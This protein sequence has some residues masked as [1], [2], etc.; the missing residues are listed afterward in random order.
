MPQGWFGCVKPRRIRRPGK[1]SVSPRC[2][3]SRR[4][5][6]LFQNACGSG[7]MIR[8]DG[9]DP[10]Y[11]A[12]AMGYGFTMPELP[13]TETIARDL[14]RCLAGRRL[15][16]VRLTRRDIVH[17]DPRP[18]SRTLPGRRV[19]RVHRRGKRIILELQPAAQLI[20]HL[21]MSGRLTVCPR[22]QSLEP[23][24]HLRIAIARTA[25]ELRFI[26]PRRFG[27]VWCLCGGKRHC[28]RPLAELGLE[29]LE[30][31]PTHF[32]RILS[33][34]RQLKALLLDQHT[35]AGLGNIYC[36]EVLHTARLHPVTRADTLDSEQAGCLF[37]AIR[38]T[39]RK[40]IQHN[41]STLKDYRR[42]NGQAGGFQKFHRVYDR[43]GQ[44]C[45]TCS[46]TIERCITAGRSTFYC[47]ACQPMGKVERPKG[48]NVKRSKRQ[49][50]YSV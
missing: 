21:G 20:F 17:G 48:R 8:Y 5:A 33:R 11:R 37:R 31:T 46:G 3:D 49:N 6:G 28:G 45:H 10:R 13:E 9:W 38:S 39:L 25:R 42:P 43:E 30:M 14:D 44:P 24:T 1:E 41:G 15:D 36:D 27:G 35:I 18:L 29:P 34:K 16:D 4:R 40:A 22:R 12:L 47:P 26:D 19:E 23:H 50:E 32:G 7:T 2:R